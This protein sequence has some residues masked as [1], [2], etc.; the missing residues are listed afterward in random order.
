MPFS[1]SL[2]L[3]TLVQQS[4]LD[5]ATARDE[6]IRLT[7]SLEASQQKC[8]ELKNT[9]ISILKK[10]EILDN[11]LAVSNEVENNLI[12]TLSDKEKENTTL[13]KNLKE[14]EH[15]LK[16]QK[17]KYTEHV[18]DA[19][20]KVNALEKANKL[21]EKDIYNLKKKVENCIDTISNLRSSKAGL[22]YDVK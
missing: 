9:N 13:D 2:P 22:E 8:D 19:Y 7:T 18:D 1:P 5:L 11:D 16:Q 20:A 6:I 14:L 3:C 12:K 10:I 4:N 17:M 15:Q 21:K